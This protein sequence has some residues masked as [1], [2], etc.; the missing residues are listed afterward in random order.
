MISQYENY[1]QY[2][3]T[4]RY[5]KNWQYGTYGNGD[6]ISDLYSYYIGIYSKNIVNGE[7]VET[8]LLDNSVLKTAYTNQN[9]YKIS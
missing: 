6:Y 5:L 1:E 4:I 3:A 7:V 9:D 2:G 8:N